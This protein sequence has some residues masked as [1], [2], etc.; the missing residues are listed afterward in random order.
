MATHVSR[1][2]EDGSGDT[3]TE[4]QSMSNAIV[5][6][7]PTGAQTVPVVNVQDNAFN[8]PASGQIPPSA[9]NDNALERWIFPRR[10]AGGFSL[11]SQV[12]WI[13]FGSSVHGDRS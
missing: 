4:L 3:V 5:E 12:S 6:E 7:T 8:D 11:P 9:T 13:D 2:A 10:I 1:V